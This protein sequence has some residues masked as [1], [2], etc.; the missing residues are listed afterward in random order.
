MLVLCSEFRHRRCTLPPQH[1]LA[2]DAFGIRGGQA[3]TTRAA[4]NTRGLGGA[5]QLEPRLRAT[6][7]HPTL[8]YTRS[9]T[10]VAGPTLPVW[11]LL[12]V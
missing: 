1:A 9:D 3:P 10:C 7:T 5:L 2:R 8:A 11:R 12:S 4:R 6:T